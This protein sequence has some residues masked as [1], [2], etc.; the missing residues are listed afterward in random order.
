MNSGYHDILDLCVEPNNKHLGK[1]AAEKMVELMGE[2]GNII[3]IY[4]DAGAM[5][6]DRKEAMHEV[7]ADYPDI[8]VTN[9]FVYAWPDFYP[10]AKAKME[11]ILQ[12]NPNPGDVSA[13]FA[14]FYGVGLAAVTSY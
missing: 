3:E 7:I 4:N 13:V 11:A 6:R 9:G 5:I 10:D 12:A 1:T 8:E 2:K 14:T